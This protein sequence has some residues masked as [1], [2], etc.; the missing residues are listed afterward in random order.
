MKIL[1]YTLLPL[2]MLVGCDEPE[3]KENENPVHYFS[4]VLGEFDAEMGTASTKPKMVGS[5]FPEQRHLIGPPIPCQ[6]LQ[7][8]NMGSPML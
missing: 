7:C 5:L 8:L 3:E 1:I 6:K 4:K 2:L